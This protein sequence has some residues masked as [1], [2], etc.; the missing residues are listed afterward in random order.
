[1]PGLPPLTC[2]FNLLP[3]PA[4]WPEEVEECGAIIAAIGDAAPGMAL[5]PYA[6]LLLA[7]D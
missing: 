7:Q 1:V 3:T 2:I 5:P 6:A 4:P